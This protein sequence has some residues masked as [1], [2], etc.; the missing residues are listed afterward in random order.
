[1]AAH[2]KPGAIIQ[3][4]KKHQHAPIYFVQGLEPFYIDEIVEAAEDLLSAEERKLNLIIGH[5]KAMNMQKIV[6]QASS[7]SMLGGKKVIIIKNAQDIEDINRKSGQAILIEYSKNPYPDNLLVL[8]YK[9]KVLFSNSSLGK[10]LAAKG[11][12]ITSPKIYE[13]DLLHWLERYVTSLGYTI[14]PDAAMALQGLIGPQLQL[15]A[16]ELKKIMINLSPQATITQD[17]IVHHVGMQKEI[18]NF[19]L[20]NALCYKN[21]GKVMQITQ[22][23]VQNSRQYPL[24]PLLSL[25]T[26]F[27]S[28]VLQLH[29]S[30]ETNPKALASQLSI[31]P[32]FMKDYLKAQKCYTAS[33]VMHIIHYLHQA[34][35]Q[36]KGIHSPALSEGAILEELITKI[37]LQ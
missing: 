35:C 15:L 25:L 5:G 7:F 2:P 6:N 32:Y 27:F 19:A 17:A 8:A 3:L 13:R 34:D 22:H 36:V 30:K 24:L 9:G 18:N 12:L 16:K 33:E 10:A 14:T 11:Y 21:K 1:M 37:L 26:T 4:L 31:H 20:Q 28:K 23:M 29:G